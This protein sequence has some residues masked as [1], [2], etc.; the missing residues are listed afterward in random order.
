MLPARYY[1]HLRLLAFAMNL[2]ES[3][4]LHQETIDT[5]EML[6][7]EFDRR[8]PHL[9]PVS[10][11][12]LMLSRSRNEEIANDGLVIVFAHTS[13]TSNYPLIISTILSMDPSNCCTYYSLLN[14]YIEA[15]R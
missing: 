13:R 14:A 7:S 9:Y 8:F 10:S 4:I 15:L 1:E 6:L 3:T 2:S 11:N 5:I 12:L